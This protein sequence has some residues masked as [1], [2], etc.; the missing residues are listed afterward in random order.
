MDAVSQGQRLFFTRLSI[1]L[2]QGL[3]LYLLYRAQDAHVWPATQGLV[4]APLLLIFLYIPLLL[5]LA[6]GEMRW[7]RTARWA[8]IALLVL[9]AVAMFDNWS[10]WPTEWDYGGVSGPGPRGPHEV[11]NILPSAQLFFIAGIALFISHALVAGA[12]HDGRFKAG[13]FTHFDVAWKLAVQLALAALFVGAFWLLLWLGAGLFKLIKLDFFQTLITHEWFAIPA[14]TLAAA[15]ALH[16]TDIRPALVVGARTLL[17]TLLSWLLPVIALITGGF[18]A[19]LPFTGLSA[20]WGFGHASALLLAATAALIVL[21]NAAHQDGAAERMPPRILQWAGTAAALLTL[22]LSVIAG[23]ALWLRIS[24]HGWTADR[25][26]AAVIVIIAVSHAV[27]CVRAVLAHG[28]WLARIEDWNF[29][30]ALLTLVLLVG[31]FTPLGSPARISVNDQMARLESGRIAPEKFDY[32]YL[33]RNGGLYGQHALEKLSHQGAAK[34]RAMAEAVLK[35]GGPGF[36][37]LTAKTLQAGI[38]VYPR[39]QAL[40]ASFIATDWT[41]DGNWQ[42]PR[43]LVEAGKPC[44]AVV[45]DLNGDH[46]PDVL[47]LEGTEG[48]VFRQDGAWTLAGKINFPADCPAIANALRDGHFTIVVPR[49]HWNDVSI[50]GLQLPVL[51][52]SLNDPPTPPCPH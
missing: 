1:G 3:A 30:C 40:P 15:G 45:T 13:Y 5:I 18:V 41:K 25:V 20:L 7:Q 26:T 46:I 39:G 31:L 36:A 6:L 42:L 16:L 37:R 21:I 51:T 32:Q 22:P 8:C 35:S 49:M 48:S 10:A 38:T 2:I 28:R 27:G 4:F 52:R 29:Y 12:A 33:R 17:L 9:A 11:P 50:A 44:D 24:Q 23:Y 34:S 19:S 43:C 14:T 47:I